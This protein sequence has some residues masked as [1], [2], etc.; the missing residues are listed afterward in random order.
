MGEYY[1]QG[2]SQMFRSMLN[3]V[4][5]PKMMS[6]DHLNI[7]NEQFFPRMDFFLI[8]SGFTG[9]KVIEEEFREHETLF[10]HMHYAPQSPNS[11][12]NL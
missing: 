6:P 12:E 11:I 4:M 9:L 7:W 1:N 5:Y 3:N 8:L 2:L 10:S